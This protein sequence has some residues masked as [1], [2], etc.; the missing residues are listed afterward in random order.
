MTHFE[1][2]DPRRS[3]CHFHGRWEP[4]TTVYRNCVECGHV[5]KGES[6]FRRDVIKDFKALN[7][8][9]HKYDPP[10]GITTYVPP[11]DMADVVICPLCSHDL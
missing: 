11:D 3:Y 10:S 2:Q 1:H 5:W 7:E 4:T 6:A 9:A 8:S